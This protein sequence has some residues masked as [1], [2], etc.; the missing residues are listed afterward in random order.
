MSDQEIKNPTTKP[1]GEKKTKS[2]PKKKPVKKTYFSSINL[3]KK[4]EEY[5]SLGYPVVLTETR[6][7]KT[8]FV[9]LHDFPFD[10]QI[11]KTDEIIRY[12][13]MNLQMQCKREFKKNV[14]NIKPI[15]PNELKY[16][17]FSPSLKDVY[18]DS[19]SMYSYE[20]ISEID[21]SKAYYSAALELGYISKDFYD[22]CLQV[23]KSQRLRLIGSIATRK[24]IWT[25]E[26]YKKEAVKVHVKEDKKLR[27]AWDNIVYYVD[28]AMNKVESYLGKDFLFYWVDGIYF[29]DRGYNARKIQMIFKEFGFDS[30]YEKLHR[31][32]VVNKNGIVE[33]DVFKGEKGEIFKP[34]TV[35]MY[36]QRAY[37]FT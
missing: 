12:E 37:K 32:D 16:N 33:L 27:M 23:P 2:K 20:G 35:P 1:K 34:F 31:V 11:F 3:Q 28:K 29:K 8:I 6:K 17:S 4:I 26:P 22:K 13:E 19:G 21:L 5:V 36:N 9:Q 14:D 15:N 7:T 30:T 18:R 10:I 25:Y 24:T